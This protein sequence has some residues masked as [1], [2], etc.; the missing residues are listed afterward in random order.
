MELGLTV[1]LRGEKMYTFLT[2]L[3]F[4][5]FAWHKFCGKFQFQTSRKTCFLNRNKN[6]NS[7]SARYSLYEQPKQ[8]PFPWSVF[9]TK[10]C[11]NWR[12]LHNWAEKGIIAWY[13]CYL[14][15]AHENKDALSCKIMLN[16][17]SFG[18]DQITFYSLQLIDIYRIQVFKKLKNF[19]SL[20]PCSLPPPLRDRVGRSTAGK[21][22]YMFYFCKKSLKDNFGLEFCLRGPP[23]RSRGW[24]GE[25]N[26]TKTVITFYWRNQEELL[27][28]KT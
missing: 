18:H 10:I 23:P 12:F 26:C 3:I 1:T 24:G 8:L 11:G 15:W 9:W 20:F 25:V 7:H 6:I 27:L 17:K 13:F 22:N 4:F 21:Q 28:N 16:G 19:V 2:K 14:S 5:T